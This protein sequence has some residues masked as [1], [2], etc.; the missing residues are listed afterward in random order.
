MSPGL[1]PRATPDLQLVGHERATNSAIVRVR[2]QTGGT[3]RGEG[4]RAFLRVPL[5]GGPPT[6]I[7]GTVEAAW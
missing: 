7:P 2:W 1:A 5:D 3:S 4:P 6:P